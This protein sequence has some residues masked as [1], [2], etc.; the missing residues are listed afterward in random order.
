MVDTSKKTKAESIT[1]Q[2]AALAEASGREV[3]DPKHQVDQWI[4]ALAAADAAAAAEL[5][6]KPRLYQINYRI[7]DA[8]SKTKG[9]AEQR[10]TAL[11][12]MIE[13]L[14][15]PEK[16]ASTST[17]IVRLHIKKAATALDLLKA[18]VASFDYLAI[19]Q[20]DSNRAKFGNANLES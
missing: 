13:S 18:P 2:L 9:T 5:N 1:E 7:K 19:A 20:I 8:T 16:H 17:W 6:S 3:G 10:R 12:A 4:A 11:V 15:P 14:E